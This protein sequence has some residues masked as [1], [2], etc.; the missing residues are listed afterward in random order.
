MGPHGEQPVRRTG[1]TKR[2]ATTA[3]VVVAACITALVGAGVWS[4]TT[5]TSDLD[6]EKPLGPI[7]VFTFVATG[8]VYVEPG[9]SR[10]VWQDGDGA[11]QDVGS[12]PWHNPV[13][14]G[15]GDP[16]RPAE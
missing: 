5:T 3:V 15:V 4:A 1:A 7:E 16:R 10:V 6:A 8:I 13:P 9:T 14:Q 12:L 11:S 2:N